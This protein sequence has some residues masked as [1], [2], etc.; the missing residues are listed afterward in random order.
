MRLDWSNLSADRRRARYERRRG[1]AQARWLQSPQRVPVETVA[2]QALAPYLSNAFGRWCVQYGAAGSSLIG[3]ADTLRR[4][5]ANASGGES[6]GLRCDGTRLPLASG[7]VDVFV[8][9]FALEFSPSPHALLREAC[10]VLNDRGVLLIVGQSPFGLGAWPRLAGLSGRV[11]PHGAQ[12]LR[13]SRLRDWLAL[14]DLELTA[15]DGFAAGWPWRG[16]A[17][18]LPGRWLADCYLLQA[19]KRVIPRTPVLRPAALS[20]KPRVSGVAVGNFRVRDRQS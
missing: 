20:R 3:Q 9:A 2:R 19:H 7:S 11:L 14:L 8:L 17:P 1:R 4:V 15:H 13:P 10:R 16:A 18:S 12:L 5:C 6:A